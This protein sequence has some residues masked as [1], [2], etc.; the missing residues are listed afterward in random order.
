MCGGLTNRRVKLLK[1]IRADGTVVDV[2]TKNLWATTGAKE[3][4]ILYP[5]DTLYVPETLKVPWSMIATILTV[6]SIGLQIV[7]NINILS[8]R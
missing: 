4:F 6:A 8:S 7:L 1:I 3:S 2:P 5:G